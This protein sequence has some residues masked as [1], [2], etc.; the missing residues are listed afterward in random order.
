MK[1]TR[2]KILI[3]LFLVVSSVTCC[4]IFVPGAFAEEELSSHRKLWD[5]IMLWVNFGILVFFFVKYAKGPLMNF[6]RG[7]R[8][9][10]EENL[11]EVEGRF[12]EVKSGM[13]AEAENLGNIDSRIAELKEQIIEM[14]RK[15]K[16]NIIE[17]GR[18][19][20]KKMIDDAIFYSDR[21]LVMAKKALLEEMTETAISIV[22]EKLSK[23]LTDEDNEKLVTSFLSSLETS[24][25]LD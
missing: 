16:E 23:G 5:N 22:G 6:L 10:I 3:V 19:T 21:R 11:E 4:F 8:K 18:I 24:E 25:T 12:N 14:G 20:A 2:K 17:E 7:T 9:E 13:D 15:E 1:Y